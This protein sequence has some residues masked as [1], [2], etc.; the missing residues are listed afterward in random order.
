MVTHDR[1]FLDAI[2]NRVWE[3]V[4]GVDPGNGRPQIPGRIELYD[5]GYAAYIL[6]RA[7]RARQAEVAA[8]KRETYCVKNWPGCD[9][10]PQR[11]LPS[12]VSVSTPPRH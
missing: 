4:P 2:C 12:R 3:V 6:A 7:E 5:G 1:W 10:A 9:A 8:A 11:A